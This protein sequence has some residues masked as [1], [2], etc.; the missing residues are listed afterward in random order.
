M[1]PYSPYG[2]HKRIAELLCESY[3]RNFGIATAVVRLFSVYGPWLRKQLLWDLCGRLREAPSTL[4]LA[5]SG[6]ESRD[7]L[8]VSDAVGFLC[9]AARRANPD[10]LMVNGATG[11]ALSV[12]QVAQHVSAAWGIDPSI[13]FSGE[14]R[15]GDPAYLVADTARA[16]AL[17]IEPR[18]R[19]EEGMAEYVRWYRD[20]ESG[21]HR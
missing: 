5:G 9:V 6:A 20:A 21:A 19:W 18:V 12:L 13:R 4:S 1:A 15:P 11:R 8:H 14:S 10:C 2:Y 17:G 3:G 16:R 7:W